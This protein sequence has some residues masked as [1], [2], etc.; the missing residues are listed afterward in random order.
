MTSFG[1]ETGTW[2]GHRRWR[3]GSRRQGSWRRWGAGASTV[4]EH[5]DPDWAAQVLEETAGHG[6]DAGANG[7]RGGTANAL[8]AVRDGGRLATITSDPPDTERGIRIASVYV[9]PDAAQLEVASQ[10]LAGGRLE[11]E[12]GASFPLS[13]ADAAL[14]RAVAGR[15]GAVVLDA[16]SD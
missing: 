5:P 9:R 15:G 7:A 12:L 10:A 11:F 6:V 13:Q 14:A 16:V 2:A 8:A 1:L 3:L 4:G